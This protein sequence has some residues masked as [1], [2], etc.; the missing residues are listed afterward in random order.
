MADQTVT[1]PRCGGTIPL[2]AALTADIEAR[3]RAAFEAQLREHQQAWQQEHAATLAAER[4]RLQAVVE[5]VVRM[6]EDLDHER[7]AMERLWKK[8]A[9]EIDRVVQNFACIYGDLQG[10][11]A[12]A[13]PDVPAL[14]LPGGM[15]E[16][17]VL[18]EE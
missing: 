6:R 10:L 9:G 8:R 3:L 11:A 14:A 13:L 17:G 2:S 16:E 12:K 4:Q 15:E 18:V 1:C 7:R 5:S